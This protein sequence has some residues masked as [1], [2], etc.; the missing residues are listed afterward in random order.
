MAFVKP[1]SGGYEFTLPTQGITTTD[2]NADPVSGQ[3]APVTLGPGEFNPTID[4]GLWRPASLGDYVWEDINHDG[5][6]NDGATGVNGVL[7]TLLD[8][9]GNV[10]STTTTF[11]GGPNNAAGYYTFT[12]LISDTYVVSFTLPAGYQWT[13]PNQGE[14]DALDSDGTPQPPEGGVGTAVTGPYVLNA[15]ESI[16]TV[17]QGVWRPASVGN[18]VWMD[19]DRDGVNNE[20]ADRGVNGVTVRLLGVEGELISTTVT[21]N[22]PNGNP[23][24]YTFTNLA[25]DRYVRGV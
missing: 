1:S 14:T 8:D 11:T 15:G 25:P 6:Q 22:D 5:I 2:S 20:P 19:D 3:T 23:G 18:Y 16:P 12:Q 13:L 10:I 21:A 17:D 7:V 9:E 4:A 24:Y